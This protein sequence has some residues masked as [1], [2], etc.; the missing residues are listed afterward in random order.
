M[1]KK[2][3]QSKRVTLKKK[4]KVA[5]KVREH[6]RKIKKID[7]KKAKSG[8]RPKMENIP[9]SWPFKEQVLQEV[10][11][12]KTNKKADE[13]QQREASKRAKEAKQAALSQQQ[14]LRMLTLSAARRGH[15]FETAVSGAAAGGG[16]ELD[17]KDAAGVSDSSKRAYFRELRKILELSDV[18]VEVLDARDPMG[19]RC[20]EVERMFLQQ[21]PQR[22]IIL[23]LNKVDLVPKE[24]TQAWLQRLRQHFPTIAF[25]ASTQSQKHALGHVRGKA[26]AASESALSSGE[27]LGG[28]ALLQLL[29]N[30]SRSQNM[31]TAITAG[32]IGFPNVGKSSLI[33]SLRRE[34]VAE[35]G[36]Q[37]GITKVAQE[38]VLDKK[39]KLLDCPGIVF[40]KDASD[41][42]VILRNC[43]RI[44]SL[45][46]VISPAAEV[47]R[48]VKPQQL[49]LLYNVPLFSNVTELLES[50]ARR[51]GKLHKGGAPDV[52]TAARMLL[53]DWNAGKIGY[54]TLPPA[55]AVTGVS[56]AA[57]GWAKEFDLDAVAQDELV[58]CALLLLPTT[59]HLSPMSNSPHF[60]QLFFR[61]SAAWTRGQMKTS[62]PLNSRGR[63]KSA[64]RFLPDFPQPQTKT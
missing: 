46:D 26:E 49:M 62:P 35:V 60:R 39:V 33:N 32:V 1:V 22:R 4:Y 14:Q 45:D 15:A 58:R 9:N 27:C 2:N 28:E 52:E 24:V 29:K 20:Q 41:P 30:Y 42:A 54:Y 53:A 8:R 7:K 50:I 17:A 55:E 40:S 11:E 19:C 31:K 47:V 12:Y 34:R 25:K 18:L 51:R 5:K 16:A 23:V 13:Q 38:I 48:R 21:G 37:P 64:R 6:H 59:I 44:D 61:F 43:V 3:T 10:K 63:Y 56:S 57:V 36:S